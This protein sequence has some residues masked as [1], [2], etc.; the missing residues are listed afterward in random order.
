MKIKCYQKFC[1]HSLKGIN[2]TD[3]GLEVLM[4]YYNFIISN[5]TRTVYETQF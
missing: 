4:D 2:R 3:A 5:T 1:Y